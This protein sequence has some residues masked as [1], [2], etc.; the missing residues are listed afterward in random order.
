VVVCWWYGEIITSIFREKRQQLS[1]S[2]YSWVYRMEMWEIL[3]LQLVDL[4]EHG[5]QWKLIFINEGSLSESCFLHKAINITN[6]CAD[7]H[8][9]M[10]KVTEN[11]PIATWLSTPK[12]WKYKILQKLCAIHNHAKMSTK[13][14]PVPKCS[15]SLI[16]CKL[17][18]CEI[19]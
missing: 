6:R 18:K 15:L 9:I 8:F 4:E 2:S 12:K 17:H 11:W 3:T 19:C 13:A 1:Q 5:D 10:K 7:S 16:Y 14:G